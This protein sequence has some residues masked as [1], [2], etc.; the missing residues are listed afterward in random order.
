MSAAKR[1]PPKLNGRK[2]VL[3]EDAY[4]L[5]LSSL[6]GYG[7]TADEPKR[8]EEITAALSQSIIEKILSGETDPKRIR[9]LALENVLLGE[10]IG[11]H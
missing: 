4:R 10:W 6:R 2:R 1:Q 9:K 8:S 3:Y 5:A 11:K 7:W